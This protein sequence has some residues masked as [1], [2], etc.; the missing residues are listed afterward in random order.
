VDRSDGVASMATDTER[1]RRHRRCMAVVVLVEVEGVAAGAGRTPEDG[2]D[3]WPIGWVFE[4]RWRG[5][6]IGATAVVDR[7][8]VI[9]QMADCHAGRGI[10][11]DIQSRC[12]VI[13]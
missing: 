2:R 1:S 4:C 3:L 13:R 9:G 10:F 5:M 7:Q 11:D 12:R 8:W 6:T